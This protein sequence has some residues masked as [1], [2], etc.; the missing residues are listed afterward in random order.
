MPPSPINMANIQAALAARSGMGNGIPMPAVS[1]MTSPS[2]PLPTGGP[3]T[4]GPG[5]PPMPIPGTPPVGNARPPMPG[6]NPTQQMAQV[7][8]QAQSPLLDPET[9][10]IA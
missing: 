5:M 6:A 1:Q 7:G 3:N 10:E 2:G 9:H 4:P 8:Q